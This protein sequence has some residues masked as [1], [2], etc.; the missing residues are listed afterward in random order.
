MGIPTLTGYVIDLSPPPLS[1]STCLKK[2]IYVSCFD[3]FH[4]ETSII[5]TVL[6]FLA[7]VLVI[8]DESWPVWVH[9]Q[10]NPR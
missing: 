2:S 3:H 8:V 1:A 6:V 7:I 10:M 9:Q 4:K 5:S